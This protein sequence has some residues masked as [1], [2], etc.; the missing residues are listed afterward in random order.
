MMTR[1]IE[2]WIKDINGSIGIYENELISKT[3]Y[4]Y[5]TLAAA[6]CGVSGEAMNLAFTGQKAAVIP[7]T[8]GLGEIGSFSRSVA[9]I[10]GH[11][12]VETFV[13]DKTDVAGIYEAHQ[14]GASILFLADDERFIAVNLKNNRIAEN[15]RATALG[16]TTA[17]EGAAGS[18]K[19]KEV[20]VIGCGEVGRQV[21]YCL[22]LKGADPVACDIDERVLANLSDEGFKT[23]SDSEQIRAYPFI[24]DASSE[25]N[26]IHKG[27]LHPE[28]WMVT[29]G[30]PLSLDLGAYQFY[31]N[32]VIHDYLQIG[33]AV[34][35]AMVIRS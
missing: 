7:V 14:T 4:D 22:K 20:L 16:Y 35:L 9:A 3:G 19:G 6:A 31:R 29:P 28:A 18:L 12:N 30:V 15:S 33:V 34:M 25:G 2:D 13:T 23:I 27:M 17:L 11:M 21:L 1:L 10:L 5:T 32:R 8:T 24:I 26:W